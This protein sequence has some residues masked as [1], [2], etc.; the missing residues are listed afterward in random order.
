MGDFFSTH[1]IISQQ[2]A[3]VNR[4][5]EV[6]LKNNVRGFEYK[7]KGLSVLLDNPMLI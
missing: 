6:F 4:F 2:D 7:N 5:F 3:F 1:I